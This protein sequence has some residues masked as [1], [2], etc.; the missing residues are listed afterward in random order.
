LQL[1]DTRNQF[2]VGPT[3]SVRD[4][5]CY[6]WTMFTDILSE[7]KYDTGCVGPTA[8]FKCS[9]KHDDVLYT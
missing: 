1:N 9:Q 5:D 6:S 4:S 8:M 2:A 7:Y 3:K